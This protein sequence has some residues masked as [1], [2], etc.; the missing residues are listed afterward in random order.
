MTRL[1][2]GRGCGNSLTEWQEGRIGIS[3]EQFEIFSSLKCKL[4]TPEKYTRWLVEIC[5]IK[6]LY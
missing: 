6:D 3:C 1:T 2:E 5:E 4:T